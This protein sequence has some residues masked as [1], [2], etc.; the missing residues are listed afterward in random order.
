MLGL[1]KQYF[2]YSSYRPGQQEIIES[3]LNGSEVLA[4]MPTGAGKSLC[5][6][7]PALAM[8]G[9]CLVV[10]PLIALMQ[11]QVYALKAR[12]IKA[13]Y[14]S[15]AQEQ[16]ETREIYSKINQG[17]VKILYVAP[18][19]LESQWFG[20]FVSQQHISFIAVD[21][22]HCI[23]EWGHDFRPSYRRINQNLRSKGSF[24]IAAFT[25]TATEK[26]RSDITKNLSM[27]SPRVF[28]RGFDRKNLHYITE[29]TKAKKHDRI[30]ELIKSMPVAGSTI[31]YCGSRKRVDELYTTLSE[32]DIS[33]TKYHAGLADGLRKKNQNDFISGAIKNI[34]ATNAF[35][36]GVDKPDVRLVIHHDLPSTIESYYQEAG[37]AGRDGEPSECYLLFKNS[38]ERLPNFFIDCTYPEKESVDKI[39]NYL[40]EKNS[41]GRHLAKKNI[42][43]LARDLELPTAKV[44]NAIAI[45][46][47]E[48][49]VVAGKSHNTAKVRFDAPIEELRALDRSIEERPR[50]HA[51]RAIVKSLPAQAMSS[52][53]DMDLRSV[54]A[55]AECNIESIQTMLLYL[56]SAGY[57]DV[58]FSSPVGTFTIAEEHKE[59][60][61]PKI[62]YSRM[63][64][65]KEWELKMLS[66]M[67]AYARTS[68]CKNKF[69][70]NYFGDKTE[71]KCGRCSSCTGR[72]NSSSSSVFL[73]IEKIV[74]AVSNTGE[75]YGKSLISA[76]LRGSYTE[77]IKERRLYN[78]DG[79]GSLEGNSSSDV[80]DAINKA[81]N[82]NRLVVS[83]DQYPI[84]KLA[85]GSNNSH[86]TSIRDDSSYSNSRNFKSNS[87]TESHYKK[88]LHLLSEAISFR[89]GVASNRVLSRALANKIAKAAS[90]GNNDLENLG[91]LSNPYLN[92]YRESL[93]DIVSVKNI[94]EFYNVYKHIDYF[95]LIKKIE[96][97]LSERPSIR[98]KDIM[99]E[100][101]VDAPGYFV[102]GIVSDLKRQIAD[103]N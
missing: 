97:I 57:A 80:Y 50:K 99:A 32:S 33:I 103:I 49:F 75:R 76:F 42:P 34:V 17:E 44:Q 53:C 69:I 68:D 2:G 54:S 7:I 48:R 20:D 26:V 84:L 55:K 58:R 77:K 46:E 40:R 59:T 56:S 62:D 29:H 35:G 3:I 16:S 22:A 67:L 1:L 52:L 14:I 91:I 60:L 4:V 37:R 19:R 11:D 72:E 25:A 36:M 21:E 87:N 79:F 23:S 10:S 9:M 41:N 38:D 70:L 81:I 74:E 27:S 64:T 86:T 73:D 66:Q 61:F 12:G 89:E 98:S 82:V 101:L 30:D 85:S 96:I 47:R 100:N 13:E 78:I 51:L 93:Y 65:R 90:L 43:E 88:M 28:I 15:S 18:E 94:S 8:E 92:K 71:K 83:G 45:L 102:R 31:I 39:W 6:Q 63:E 95:A 24:Q 5:F